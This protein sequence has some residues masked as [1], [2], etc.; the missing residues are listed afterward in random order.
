MTT[1]R[2]HIPTHVPHDV[3]LAGVAPLPPTVN[4][5]VH[6]LTDVLE[7]FTDDLYVTLLEQQLHTHTWGPQHSV[8]IMLD[9]SHVA[10]VVITT[11][12]R[13][14]EENG[15][16]TED[17]MQTPTANTARRVARWLLSSEHP[18]MTQL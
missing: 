8:A 11:L 13:W 17:A 4:V 3:R 15:M 9:A 14:A 18:V 2:H 10:D 1:G 6:M 12:R 7:C 16:L 5:K